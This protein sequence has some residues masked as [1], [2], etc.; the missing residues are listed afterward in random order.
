MR[1]YT[2][3]LALIFFLSGCGGNSGEE[4]LVTTAV[5]ADFFIQNS[6]NF[7]ITST[8]LSA[9]VCEDSPIESGEKKLVSNF[10]EI[11]LVVPD[12][13]QL[14]PEYFIVINTGNNQMEFLSVQP[15]E[16]QVELEESGYRSYLYTL[17][18]QNV[19]VNE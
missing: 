11:G 3:T 2:K 19:T 4:V 8:C 12:P 5:E 7:T 6:S 13:E 15:I 1:N 17:L 9:S 16:W 10:I 14:V 18:D